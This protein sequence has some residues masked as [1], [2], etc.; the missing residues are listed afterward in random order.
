M[1]GKKTKRPPGHPA[2]GTNNFA[3]LT[4]GE[5]SALLRKRHGWRI[6]KVRVQQICARAEE[7]LRARLKGV[8]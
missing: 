3:A 5:I 6:G 7:K 4:F 2:V 8:L 1:S